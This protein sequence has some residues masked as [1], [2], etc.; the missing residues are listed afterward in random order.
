MLIAG[1]SIRT[2][3]YYCV[4][5]FFFPFFLVRTDNMAQRLVKD[6]FN[7]IFAHLIILSRPDSY[8]YY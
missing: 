3:N 1:I 6:N 5:I 8:C 2:P 4:T 7:Y